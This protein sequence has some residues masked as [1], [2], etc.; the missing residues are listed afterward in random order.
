MS[1][2]PALR[3]RKSGALVVAALIAFVGT[4]PFAGSR[5]ELTPIILIP[6]AI[7]LWV[8]RAGTDVRPGGL[9]VRAL[10]GSTDIPWSR[11]DQLAPDGRGRVSA[12]LTDGKVIRLTGV[13]TANLPAVITAGGQELSD[14]DHEPGDDDQERSNDDQE[15]SDGRAPSDGGPGPGTTAER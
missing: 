7:L 4:V 3:V 13:T 1:R 11:I 8:V 14:N 15:L 12:L 2:K 9:R 6:L 10:F 5:W